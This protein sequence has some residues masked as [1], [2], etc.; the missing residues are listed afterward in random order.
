MKIIKPSVEMDNLLKPTQDDILR[1]LEKAARTCYKSFDKMSEESHHRLF[2]HILSNK[3][4]SVLEHV[5]LTFR[6]VCDRG[7]SHEFVRHRLASYSQ[8]STR[9]VKY[10]DIEVIDPQFD[11]STKEGRDAH[12]EWE[13]MCNRSELAYKHMVNNLKIKP[14]QARSVLPTCL[15]TEFVVSMNIRQVMHFL[16][17]RLFATGVHPQM[18]HIALL[19]YQ[20][21]MREFPVIFHKVGEQDD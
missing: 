8:E 12:S 20:E 16:E 3:H 11:T 6:V 4:M 7:I 14:E 5:L 10:D 15:K 18:S 21:V 19:L 13:Y 17:T 2:S 1:H 9:Y